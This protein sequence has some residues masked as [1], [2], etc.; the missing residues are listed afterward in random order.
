MVRE[1]MRLANGP[2]LEARHPTSHLRLADSH[3]AHDLRQKLERST[4][5]SADPMTTGIQPPHPS[6]RTQG[7]TAERLPLARPPIKKVTVFVIAYRAVFGVTAICRVL[8]VPVASV[9]SSLSRPEP[10]R[11][12]ADEQLKKLIFELFEDNYSVYGRK[13]LRKALRRELMLP[14]FLGHLITRDSV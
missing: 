3:Q 9:R 2:V 10:A 13:K 5:P 6:A 14:W 8:G 11:V 1:T 12:L 7:W 4:R